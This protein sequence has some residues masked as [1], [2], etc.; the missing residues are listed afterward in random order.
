VLA[1]VH[2]V[3]AKA[4]ADVVLVVALVAFAQA[5]FDFVDTGDAVPGDDR[6]D[7]EGAKADRG[8]DQSHAR[9]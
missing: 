9:P 5:A 6:D 7:A 3:A 1:S 4:G 2:V 8:S